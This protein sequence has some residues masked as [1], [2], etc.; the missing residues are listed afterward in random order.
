MAVGVREIPAFAGMTV[1]ACRTRFRQARPTVAAADQPCC[2]VGLGP[3]QPTPEW[4]L[5]VREGIG[6][7]ERAPWAVLAPTAALVVTA[8]I[9]VGLAADRD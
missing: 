3:R 9:A 6:Y 1:C 7:L 2:F 4:G 8:M 5:V